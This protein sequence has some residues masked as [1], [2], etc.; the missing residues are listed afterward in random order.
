SGS[1]F[2]DGQAKVSAVQGKTVTSKTIKLK[3][4]STGTIKGTVKGLKKN[5]TVWLYDTK[6]KFSY[7]IALASKSKLKIN[8]KV[9]PGTYRR[10]VGGETIASEAVSVKAKQPAKAGTRKA[11][12]KRTTGSGTIKS[13]NGKKLRG[14]GVS[15]YDSY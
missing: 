9:A 6:S 5:D 10:V 3:A 8:E 4:Q 1:S 14:A 2:R 11:S 7:Q 12:K 13:P 15:V